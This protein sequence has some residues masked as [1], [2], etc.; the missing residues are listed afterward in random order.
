MIPDD[1]ETPT[2]PELP[3]AKALAEEGRLRC[4]ECTGTA[5][6]CPLCAGMG[7]VDRRTWAHWHA[8]RAGRP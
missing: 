7:M 8:V 5:P 2:S 6:Q 1:D 3:A 4:P